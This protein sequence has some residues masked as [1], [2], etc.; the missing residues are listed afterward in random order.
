[1]RRF[2]DILSLNGDGTARIL[3]YKHKKCTG[4]GSCNVQVPGS[5]LVAANPIGAVP[6]DL[7]DVRILK[8]ASVK[9]FLFTYVLPLGLFVAGYLLGQV[10]WPAGTGP[11]SVLL[12]FVL[13]A[14]GL[15]VYFRFKKNYKP[16][17]HAK[18]LKIKPVE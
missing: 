18:I 10:I 8:Q 14:A 5:V 17:F 7:V 6:G 11:Q 9:E 4:C 12:A 13:L 1:M 15:A 2:A 3:I 16:V